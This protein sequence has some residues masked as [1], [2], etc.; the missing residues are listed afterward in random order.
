[1]ATS[2]WPARQVNEFILQQSFNRDFKTRHW[3]HLFLK[4]HI[5]WG[6]C[7]R[8]IG[9]GSI[10]RL[11]KSRQ[12]VLRHETRASGSGCEGV[13]RWGK[14]GVNVNGNTWWNWRELGK[15]WGWFSIPWWKICPFVVWGWDKVVEGCNKEGITDKVKIPAGYLC[16]VFQPSLGRMDVKHRRLVRPRIIARDKKWAAQGIKE[17]G[18]QPEG[19]R[20][21]HI[22]YLSTDSMCQACENS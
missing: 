3:I 9:K 18:K 22:R 17:N 6:K 16:G 8:Q 20:Q 10:W 2:D 4:K 1:M 15:S 14:Y 13:D 21:C 19:W 7:K 11:R 12:K 5:F